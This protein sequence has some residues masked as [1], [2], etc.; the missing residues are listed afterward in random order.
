VLGVF[1]GWVV[2]A[3]GTAEVSGSGFVDSVDVYAGD[4]SS[5]TFVASD[6]SESA[7]LVNATPSGDAATRTAAGGLQGN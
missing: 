1:G 5:F 3:E 4:G 7:A 2:N 6:F